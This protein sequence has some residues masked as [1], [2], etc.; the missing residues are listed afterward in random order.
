MTWTAAWFSRGIQGEPD[1]GF[2]EVFEMQSCS[3]DYQQFF[4]ENEISRRAESRRGIPDSDPDDELEFADIPPPVWLRR[5]N[6]SDVFPCCDELLGW[7]V[8][9][10]AGE[11]AD[12]SEAEMAE[13]DPL[14]F[15][16]SDA[17]M[18][19]WSTMVA[20]VLRELSEPRL[21]AP[22]L[23]ARARKRRADRRAS[24]G[25]IMTEE[26]VEG[27]TSR[28]PVGNPPIQ[29]FRVG[30]VTVAIWSNPAPKGGFFNTVTLDRRFQQRDGGWRSTKSLRI[31]DIPLAIAALQR[32]MADLVDPLGP[33]RPRS[34]NGA[35]TDAPSSQGTVTDLN[36]SRS[37][38]IIQDQAGGENLGA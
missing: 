26:F 36:R 32:A 1:D 27:S 16:Y 2:Q 35:P 7:P 15:V 20:E 23:P 14:S 12:L 38:G 8:G 25:H 13:T 5:R 19:A 29:R 24:G 18:E 22:P 37:T 31:N 34:E 28:Q 30:T 3:F 17:E 9:V 4:A 11:F 10:C 6:Q 21:S 33:M